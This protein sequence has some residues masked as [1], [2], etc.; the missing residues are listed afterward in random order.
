MTVSTGINLGPFYFTLIS[1][2]VRFYIRIRMQKQLS[3]DDGFL[4]F[5]IGCLI[6]AMA[7]MFTFTEKMYLVEV[8][9]LGSPKLQLSLKFFQE[10]FD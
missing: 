7:M 3:V 9:L 5:G 10:S 2:C 8:V 6:C 4:L 1:A